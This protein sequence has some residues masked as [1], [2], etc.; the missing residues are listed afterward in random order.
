[1]RKIVYVT[2]SRAEYGVIRSTLE[3]IQKHK[4]LKLSLIVTGMH[5]SQVFG[6]TV[7]EI[8]KDGFKIDAK[9]NILPRED[10]G[11]AMAKYLGEGIIRIAE[12]LEKIKPDIVLVAGDRTEALAA[13]IAATY[14]NIPVAHISGGDITEGGTID[15]IIR[16]C[17]TKFAHIHFPATKKSAEIIIRM[18]EDPSRV[19]IVGNPGVPI[20]YK[21]SKKELQQTARRF[22]LDLAKPIL[23]VIQHPVTTEAHLAD[24]QMRETMEA[25]REL[26]MQTIVVYPNADAGAQ[27][28]I[29]IINEYKKFSFIQIY[30]SIPRKTFLQLMAMSSVLIGNSSCALIEAPSFNLPAV[31]IGKRQEGRERGNNIIDAKPKKEE[32]ISA[33]RKALYDKKFREQVKKSKSPYVRKGAEKNIV[34]ILR[35]IKISP[36]LLQKS[37]FKKEGRGHE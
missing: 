16:H 26:G 34:K 10:T 5:L 37:F 6:K 27:G 12:A 29:K 24:K 13:A 23:L 28:M 18:G 17:I 31:N 15:D 4:D 11:I 25:I 30:K 3:E 36:G 32:I 2:G 7:K 19:F 20:K 35:K 9:I 8:E 22:K 14:L 21:P 33:I 1:M